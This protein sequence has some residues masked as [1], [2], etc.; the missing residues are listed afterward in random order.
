MHQGP[1]GDACRARTVA[2][3]LDGVGEVLEERVLG[4]RDGDVGQ[5]AGC[6][7]DTGCWRWW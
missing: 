5:F 1:G 4:W 6:G 2:V 3:F 7:A